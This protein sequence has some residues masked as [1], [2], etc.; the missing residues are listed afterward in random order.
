[1]DIYLIKQIEWLIEKLESEFEPTDKELHYALREIF[2]IEK[3]LTNEEIDGRIR[4]FNNVLLSN[5]REYWLKEL[6]ENKDRKIVLQ[7]G[8]I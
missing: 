2:Q 4:S 8:S 7:M 3:A 1:M 5:S 6:R